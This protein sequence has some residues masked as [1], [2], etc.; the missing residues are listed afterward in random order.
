[1]ADEGTFRLN[2]PD[3]FVWRHW[4]GELVFFDEHSGDTRLLSGW[5]GPVLELIAERQ[6]ID[7]EALRRDLASLAG[8]PDDESL[9]ERVQEAID[10]LRGFGMV[11]DGAP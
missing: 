9:R 7:T 2:E 1:M 11:S 8:L 6:P 4:E 10:M 5:A 3:R